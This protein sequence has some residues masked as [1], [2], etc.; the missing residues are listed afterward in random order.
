MDKIKKIVSSVWFIPTISLI[1]IFLI[2][3]F[4]GPYFAFADYYPLEAVSNRIIVIITILLVY[5]LIQLVKYHRKV[6]NQQNMVADITEDNSVNDVINAESTELKDK[7]NQA[8]SL[9]KNNKAGPSSLTELPWYMIIGSPGS[10]KT[11]LL[12]NSGLK[13]PLFNEFSNQAIQ[14]VGGTKNCDWWITQDAVLLDTAGRYTSQDSHQEAD[15]SGWTNFLSLIKKYRKKP[16]SGLLVSFS[17]SDLMTLSEYDLNQ[18]VMQMKQRIAEVNDFFATKFPIYIIITKSDM[19]AGFSQFYET[20]SHKE[21][22]QTFGITFDRNESVAGDLLASF[23]QKFSALMQS[24][25]R[26]Q[27]QRISL[28]RDASRK[29]LIYSFS[30]QFAD[31][32]PALAN[33]IENL[34]KQDDGLT[35][36]IV[37]G[38]YFTSGTQYGAP[39]DRMIAKVSQNF[40]LKN[41]A[42]A[43]WNNDQ[44]SY[45]IKELLKDVVFPESDQFGVL[46]GYENRKNTI[47][48]VSMAVAG[49]F[50]IAL[51]I[52]LFISYSN[53]DHYITLSEKSV[54]SW[55]EQYEN[56]NNS[57]DI[58]SYIPALN[59][60]SNNISALIELDDAQFSGLG[61]A[62]SDSLQGALTAS[63][64]RLLSTVLLPYVKT[65][66]ELQLSNTQ[67]ASEQYQALKAYLMLSKTDK[68]DDEFLIFW[69]QR[70]L[71]NNKYFTAT[72]FVQLSAHIEN[73]IQNKMVLES[74]DE[75]LVAKTRQNLRSQP[76]ADIY[77]KQFKLNYIKDTEMLSMAQL[78]G[79]DWRSV[80]ST[81]KDDILTIAKLYTPDVFS[82]VTS[83]DIKKYLQKVETESWVL[84]E[85][86]VINKG[87][88]GEQLER[89]YARDYVNNWQGL[90][91]SI[92]MNKIDNIDALNSALML[93]SSVDSP[94]FLLLDSASQATKLVEETSTSSLAN[95]SAK[96]SALLDKS[97]KVNA[98]RNNDTSE[99]FITSQFNKLHELMSDERK[100]VVQQKMSAVIS[101]ISVALTFSM[102]NEQTKID[103]SAFSSLDAFGYVQIEP[104]NLWVSQL[105]SNIKNM[106]SRLLKNKIDKVWR[107][108]I[109]AQCN[110]IISFKYPFEKSAR[111]DASLRDLQDLFGTSGVIHQ[112]F[113]EHI[114][115][116]IKSKAYPWQWKDNVAET[117][118]FTPEVLAFFEKQNRIRDSLFVMDGNRA[119]LDFSL[120]PIFLDSRLAKFK[121]S[122]HGRSMSYQFGRP[123]TT[124]VSW[125]PENFSANSQ[126]TFIRRDGSEVVE[127]KNGLF[128]FFRL[129]DGADINQVNRN[130]VEVTFSKNNFKAIYELSGKGKVNPVIFSQL[131]NYKCL[132]A[133]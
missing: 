13:F 105:S 45:F 36:G 130:K 61:L 58:R 109:L 74:I 129:L 124:N 10:G 68:R 95:L 54:D 122:I 90:L 103:E 52:G 133:L 1:L 12:S 104:L 41:T 4:A 38:L 2:I 16:V 67:E 113:L 120:K 62:Q 14:G 132:T 116:L 115:P 60:F 46:T 43:L 87:A 88:L 131:A 32:K 33:V 69:L 98:L 44:R 6:K 126:F 127:I 72:E 97:K 93:L 15:K 57:G 47:K 84:G 27:W 112:F 7:F 35:T 24:I 28:E 55:S 110:D 30:D 123:I 81:D 63:Y 92:S 119:Q 18:Q 125:P 70:N 21:R 39:I 17:M 49:V 53:N 85:G 83:S 48:K 106:R 42:K 89:I 117:H 66:V 99:Y 75:Q 25:T 96:G 11:T 86:N 80:M 9:L 29:S 37:R 78:A 114:Q 20:F 107:E 121:M 76:I 34:S 71:N 128:A 5:F 82:Q 77:Y 3:W 108:E 59:D 22:E 94:L 73:L 40:G 51:S 23:T 79:T 50:T 91:N 111:A 56:S 19:V 31:L 65:E 102:K 101:E 26:R 100:T 8:F 118:G 64:G